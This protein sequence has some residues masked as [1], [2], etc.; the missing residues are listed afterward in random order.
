M[1][2]SSVTR[3]TGGM[4][5]R[6]S[7]RLRSRLRHTDGIDAWASRSRWTPPSRRSAT[8][9]A[10]PPTC[11]EPKAL[12]RPNR[13]PSLAGTLGLDQARLAGRRHRLQARMDAELLEEPT[14]LP[15][16]RAGADA[17]LV[18]DVEVVQASP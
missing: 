7:E 8:I 12:R 4:S 2:P 11:R 9:T 14:N 17:Q 5:L 16:N 1:A 13:G 10:A 18:G 15:A 6:P 3:V